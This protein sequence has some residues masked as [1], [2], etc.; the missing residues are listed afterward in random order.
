MNSLQLSSLAVMISNAIM[1]AF[2]FFK[3]RGNRLCAIWGSFC[4]CLVFWGAGGFFIAQAKQT[5]EALF[6][7]QVVYLGVIFLPVLYYH[8][9]LVF[10]ELKRGVLFRL[11]YAVSLA[12]WLTVIL[13]PYKFFGEARWLFGQFYWFKATLLYLTYFV[14]LCGLLG[15]SFLLLFKGLK[16]SQGIKHEQ[17]KY[18]IVSTVMGWL[19]GMSNYWLN[20]GVNIYPHL[21][22]L[23]AV[24]PFI[25]GYAIVKH[26]LM[27]IRIAIT[28]AGMFL[29]VY[30]LVLGLPLAVGCLA[31]QW[32]LATLLAIILATFGPLVY[33]LLYN[34]FLM[35]LIEKR[36]WYEERLQSWAQE[37][38]SRRLKALDHFSASMA[39]EIENPIFAVTGMTELAKMVV[40]EDMAS[41]LSSQ[42]MDYLN[43]HFHKVNETVLRI[44]R[45]IKSV[46]EF[47][48]KPAGEFVLLEVDDLATGLQ[49]IM[50]PQFNY[51]GIKFKPQ[52]EKG[53]RVNG[54]RNGL[55]ELLMSL[56]LNAI[57]A[58]KHSG[59]PIKEITLKINRSGPGKVLIELRDNGYGIPKELLED[60]FLDFVTTKASSEGTGMGL[61]RARKIVELHH[62]RIWAESA[63]PDQGAAFFVELPLARDNSAK[64]PCDK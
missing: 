9:V 64:A 48:S 33:R 6:W 41:K 53:L 42:D 15:Y 39:H 61:S 27:D 57:H 24:Y 55:S 23:V 10:L 8:F 1:A 49:D 18:F 22:F 26:Q 45:M 47:A 37:E 19:G 7:W 44:S 62:G 63:G 34:E 28:R 56:A 36:K 2:L 5:N 16:E 17:I 3:C 21:N 29:V 11:T 35:H 46:R 38:Q 58:V 32:V 50:M 12:L 13:I 59:Q 43:Q 54:D 30:T 52:A 4:A 51:E 14:F 60:I 40:N 31:H 25:I 20:L